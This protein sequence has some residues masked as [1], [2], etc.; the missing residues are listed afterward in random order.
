MSASR[1]TPMRRLLCSNHL[2]LTWSYSTVG[3]L[4][5]TLSIRGIGSLILALQFLLLAVERAATPTHTQSEVGF[6]LGYLAV[7]GC[8]FCRTG[9]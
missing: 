4:E 3:C 6:L 8:E 9:T 7:S 1:R 2:Y 5:V